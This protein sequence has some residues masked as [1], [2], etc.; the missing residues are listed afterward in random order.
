MGHERA[1]RVV[2]LSGLPPHARLA[3]AAAPDC[4]RFSVEPRQAQPPPPPTPGRSCQEASSLGPVLADRARRACAAARATSGVWDWEGLLP[5]LAASL[6][7]G[8]ARQNAAATVLVWRH[9][10]GLRGSGY[11]LRGRFGRPPV[12]AMPTSPRRA[13]LPC[14]RI[15]AVFGNVLLGVA[16][17]GVNG[18]SAYYG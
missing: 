3:S 18:L 8:S 17:R 16:S 2:F 6:G 13:A 10:H 4:A 14:L 5:W 12:A 1:P 11:G 7:P 9:H 15:S